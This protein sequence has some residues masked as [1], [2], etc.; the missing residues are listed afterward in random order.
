[1]RRRFTKYPSTSINASWDPDAG[2][3]YRVIFYSANEAAEAEALLDREGAW[4]DCGDGD[5]MLLH[6]DGLQALY[7]ST[8]DFDEV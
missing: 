3:T 4:Y 5:R 7:D 2:E 6:K 8:I 1:M